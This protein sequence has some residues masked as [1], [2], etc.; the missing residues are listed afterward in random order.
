MQSISMATAIS[1][2]T[3]K[4]FYHRVSYSTLNFNSFHV[5]MLTKVFAGITYDT[6]NNNN[7]SNNNNNNK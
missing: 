5:Q 2:Y 1:D 4:K 3:K 6:D 7:N